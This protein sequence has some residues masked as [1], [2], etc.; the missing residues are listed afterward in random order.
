MRSDIVANWGLPASVG[1][2]AGGAASAWLGSATRAG[3]LAQA[4]WLVGVVLCVLAIA[5]V[6]W[7]ASA[8]VRRDDQQ[9]KLSKYGCPR[10][11]Y[12]P[13]T[14]DLESSDSLS[15]P[16]CGRPVYEH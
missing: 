16:I 10:C 14:G 3:S 5:T 15:C 7:T 4:A 8:R 2:A 11:G 13:N 1:L 6:V 12:T 9:R